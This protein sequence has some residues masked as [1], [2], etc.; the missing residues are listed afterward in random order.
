MLFFNNPDPSA[1]PPV[2]SHTSSNNRSQRPANPQ[3]FN[4]GIFVKIGVTL[5][6]IH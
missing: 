1:P 6:L 5:L 2:P 4:L 3:Q